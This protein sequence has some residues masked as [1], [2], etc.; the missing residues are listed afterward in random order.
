MK[1]AVL[2]AGEG[3]HL[4]VVGIVASKLSRDFNQ[5]AIV[6]SI[7]GDSASGSG[8]SIGGIN[9]I[10]VLAPASDLLI[11]YGGHQMAAG[12]SLK[13]ENI[14][15]FFQRFDDLIAAM[16]L[17]HYIPSLD[18]DGNVDFTE[19]DEN[20]FE[21]LKKLEPFGCG[22][23]EPIYRFNNL[24]IDYI[25]PLAEKHT[26]GVFRDKNNLT[27][28]FIAFNRHISEWPKGRNIDVVGTPKINMFRGY[29][30]FQI[31]VKDL[32]PSG[33]V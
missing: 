17:K 21:H 11:Q 2:V 6:L 10:D 1:N 30:T 22:N 9:L 29:R 31:Q 8:R 24:S 18:I 3:W 14:E 13:T 28:D 25:S 26:R 16:G 19:L 4:G 15:K 33:E 7:D 32:R 23:P 5:P 12:L 20:F 27:M